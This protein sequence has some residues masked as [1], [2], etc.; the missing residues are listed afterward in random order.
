MIGWLT[1]ALL[2]LAAAILAVSLG[3]LGAAV[4]CG[5]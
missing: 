1:L 5:P 2:G 3:I 4:V